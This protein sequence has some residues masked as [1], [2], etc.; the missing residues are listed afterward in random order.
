MAWLESFLYDLRSGIRSLS[1]DWSFAFAVVL[2][3]TLAI[4]VN[5]TAFR[6]MDAMLF[7]GFPLVKQN[8]RMVFI[9]EQ[10]PTPGCCVSYMDYEVWR[11][12]AHSFQDMAFWAPKQ[13]TLGET[14]GQA[15]DVWS[16][17]QTSNSFRVLGVQPF[18][19]RDFSPR[20]EAPGAEPVVIVSHRYWMARLGGRTN[21]IG[22]RIFI[23]N[24]PVT[25]IGVMPED[26]EFPQNSEVWLPLEQNAALHTIVANG[27]A[28]FGRLADG[29]SEATARAEVEAINARLAIERPATNRDVR[30]FVRNFT[31]SLAGA[32]GEIVY[33]SLWAGTWLVLAI[34]C[35]NLANL[36]LARAQGRTREICTRMALGAGRTRV[37]RQFLLES[38]LLAAIAGALA[39]WA[40][41]WS[42]QLWAAATQ[43][44][45]QTQNYT[46]TSG[47][48]AYL[49]AVT[50]GVAIVITLVPVSRLWRLDMQ[51]ALKD[52]SRSATMNLRAKRFSA[53]LVT[54]Q[55]MLA[56]V[57]M[58]GAGVLGH[59]LWN[60]LRADIGVQ[61]PENVLIGRLTLPRLEYPTPESRIA[62]FDLLSKGLAATTGVS[63]ASIANGRPV[64]DFEP[65]PMELETQI[66]SI[67]GAP[68]FS[69]GP[70]YFHAMG[71]SI[72]AGRDFG[73]SDRLTAEP[74]VIVNQRFAETHFPGQN[75]IG[76]RIRLYVKRQPEPGQWR[77]IVGV[78]SNVMQNDAMRQSFRPVV[79]LPFSQEP[80]VS[81]WFFVRAP[82]MSDGM[83]AAVRAQVR[84][85]Y[86]DL[87]I[88]GFATLAESLRSGG[89]QAN[90]RYLELSKQAAVAPIF[91]ALALLLAAIGLYAVVSRSTSRRTKEIGI[92]MALG[93]TSREI[94]SL[95]LWQAMAPVTVGLLLGLAASLGVNRILQSQLV[96]VSPYDVLT[97]VL[98]P[99]ILISVAVLAT[100]VPV[101][102]ASQLDPAT[103]LHHD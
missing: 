41:A 91:A 48:V 66:G 71:A 3:L 15:R 54:G 96:G 19:G 42:I 47:T 92:R 16:G 57:L 51:G 74:V 29:A 21:I 39:W 99:L 81:A 12:Q 2:T 93:A 72:L 89:A 35:A 31:R 90:N 46:T 101:R 17:T 50:L 77:T 97:L 30:P 88:E 38:L 56:I 59:S 100:M 25:V 10:F 62:S 9:D 44:S 5:V 102:Q 80:T 73:N 27:G 52:E 28:V 76:Q 4:A 40:S 98:A 26:F 82:M 84:Q 55:M 45:Y 22:D 69:I 78:A 13:V 36:A 7:R 1:R 33:G 63:S 70:G 83:A 8:A 37:V 11:E 20:D 61:S 65:L 94:H 79:Y 75:A 43:T 53:A 68:K 95:I 87:E 58:S 86:P 32:N 6:V 85:M 23:N 49:A 67:Q 14:S 103:A 64:D 18:L 24:L 60:V 34:A